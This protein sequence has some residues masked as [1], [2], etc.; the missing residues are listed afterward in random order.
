MLVKLDVKWFVAV[1][2]GYQR[3]LRVAGGVVVRLAEKESDGGS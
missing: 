1:E 2:F 3:L